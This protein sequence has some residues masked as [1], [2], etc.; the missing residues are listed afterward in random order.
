[1]FDQAHERAV[2]GHHQSI[3]RIQEALVDDEFVL[4]YQ[5]KINMR[6]G[7]VIGVEALIR[8]QHPEQGL[9]SPNKFLP[10]IQ[11][12]PFAITLGEW[13]IRTALTQCSTW[14]QL[15][16]HLPVSVNVDGI[17][18]QAPNFTE[19]LRHTL[20]AFPDIMPDDL[21]IEALESSALD[22][23]QRVAVI[24]RDCQAV[25]VQFALDDFG[26]GYSTLAY[27]RYLPASILKIDKSFVYNMLDN[28]AD[29]LMLKGV[30]SLA[31][32]FQRRVIAEGVETLAHAHALLALGCDYG[33]GYAFARPMPANKLIEWKK[34]FTLTDDSSHQELP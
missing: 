30:L 28:K 26:T 4:F 5:P 32:A 34:H 16:I 33:Q 10:V 17:H 29:L 21:E 1:M 22:D 27:L 18:L 23:I 25:G 19:W 20:E 24:M 3:A 7:E 14:K 9:L 2:R 15:G 8:W 11:Q 13:V 6:S 12:H 31:D